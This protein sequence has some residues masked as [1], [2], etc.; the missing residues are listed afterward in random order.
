MLNIL[1]RIVQDI[2]NAANFAES[3][4]IMVKKVRE[5]IETQA[6]TL[7]IVDKRRKQFVL[8]A[9]D[10]LNPDTVGKFRIGLN[11]GLVGYVG[12]REEPINIEN[13]PAHPNYSHQAQVGEEKFKA[14]LG[15]PV[16]HHRKLLGVIVLQQEEERKY[17]E[18]ESAFLV[19][20]A[21]HIA[22]TIAHAE[23]SGAIALLLSG[24]G[25]NKLPQEACFE[26]IASSS[27]VAIGQAVIV[28]TPADLDAIPDKPLETAEQIQAEIETFTQALNAAREEIRK[29][30]ERIAK[31]L[32]EEEK[33]LFEVYEKILDK[34]GIGEEV[35]EAIK[36]GNWAEGAL[37]TVIKDHIRQFNAMDD[38]YLRERAEDIKDLGLKVLAHL[39]KKPLIAKDYPE[40]CILVGDEVTASSLADVPEGQLAGVVSSGGSANSHVAIL[41]R[42]L[43]VPAVMG[44]S[45][46]SVSNRAVDEQANI[47]VDGYY[48]QVYVA[49][50]DLLLK[51]FKVLAKE[52][53]ELDLSLEDLH[54][55]PAV[56]P[57]GYHIALFVNT[58]LAAD[59]SRSLTVGAEGVGLFRSE[60][61]FM[62]KDRFPSEQEQKL[63]YRQLLN[64][65]SPR[66]VIMRTLDV[67]GDKPLPYFPVVEDNP[68]LGW[69]GIRLTLDQPD[70]FL[71]QLRAMLKASEGFDNLHI[72]LPMVSC[73]TELDDALALIQQ[74]YEEVKEEGIDIVRPPIGAMIEVP[75]AVYLAKSFARRL[76]FLSVGSNDLVQYLLAVDRNNSRVAN[77]YDP[78]NPAVLMALKHIVDS[79]HSEGKQVSLCGEMASDPVAVILLIAM[80]FDALSMSSVILPRIKWVIRSLSMKQAKDI[81][82]KVLLLENPAKTRFY[83][84]QLLEEVGLGGL[85]RAGK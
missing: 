30:G 5:A 57:D 55:L 1:N 6:C 37:R 77:L 52:E 51:Q 81:F 69:R 11:E 13:A 46:L 4:Q 44:V 16:F 60:V 21:A 10:G 9:T 84:E 76:D 80:G 82:E 41:A 29:L 83:L 61:P 71:V 26:G 64:A 33:A 56:T 23:V 74:A 18:S 78:L 25:K 7:F 34:S 40:N 65:F 36:T 3:M 38:A 79:A 85:I 72:M 63:I 45:G 58:G 8:L 59:A 14:F 73:L 39:Q 48:G 68:F 31:N 42:A 75:S 49:P 17:D 20:L 19:T 50:S 22:G 43:G 62:V 47:I 54:G 53:Q 32:P 70:I 12:K 27:G 67:G 66:P 15:V 28:Y 24:S 2:N 35:I